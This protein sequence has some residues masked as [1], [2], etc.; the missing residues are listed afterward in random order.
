M[1]S[2]FDRINLA[3]EAEAE[4]MF[5]DCCGSSRWA[6]SMIANRPFNSEREMLEIAS[7]IWN[8]LKTE[9]LLEAFRSHPQIGETK[10]A[11]KQE[12][13]SAAWSSD[14]QAGM[15]SADE[16]LKRELANA[17]REYHDKFGFI[18]IVCAAVKSA[19]EMLER[20]RARLA[21]DRDTEIAIAAAEQQKI[22]EIRL[23]KLLSS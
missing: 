5:R 1:R 6:K 10:A 12:Q 11:Q 23:R 14:E 4:S 20:C 2:G 9:D 22:T 13:R 7:S 17:N 19:R 18:F 15:K 8:S 21:N 3:D 16:S